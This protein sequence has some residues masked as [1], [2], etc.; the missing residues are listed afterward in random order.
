M[1]KSTDRK[2]RKI[3]GSQAFVKAYRVRSVFGVG[4]GYL[5]KP[6]FV[7]LIV[8]TRDPISGDDAR[9]FLPL[10]SLFKVMTDHAVRKGRFFTE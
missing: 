8:F 7:T 10:A 2:G 4:G 9:R 5:A 1:A 3:I 6:M